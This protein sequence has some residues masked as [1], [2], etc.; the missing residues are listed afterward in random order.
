[1]RRRDAVRHWRRR[2]AAV[3]SSLDRANANL[4]QTIWNDAAVAVGADVKQMGEG[5]LL[6][7]RGSMQTIVWRHLVMIDHQVT[8]R[9]SMNKPLSQRLLSTVGLPVPDGLTFDFHDLTLARAFVE[10]SSLPC[11]V[12]P[13]GQASGT[14][15][16]CGVESR[17]DLERAAVRAARWGRELLVERQAQGGE[18]RVLVLDGEVLGAV[19]RRAT[20]VHG[21]GRSSIGD[22]IH[23]ENERRITSGWA[24]GGRVLSV[25]LDCLLTLRRA[26]YSL[27]SVPA[28]GAVVTVKTSVHENRAEDNETV[29]HISEPLAGDVRRAAAALELRLAG[30]DLMTP[31]PSTTLD[32]SGGVI[33]EVNHPAGLHF[34]YQVADPK[35]ATPV[36]VPI[37][38]SLLG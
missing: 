18:Y 11:V 7:R 4:Y 32:Q 20:Q 38:N 3:R 34:H 37:L 17:D 33:L 2:S 10:G 15:V 24:S 30:V 23:A 29:T 6:L 22:L 27:G 8:Q 35:T 36:A 21:D 31:D 14:G 28:E 12:K 1:M 19:R 16:T 5:F 26:G 25:D 9:L 13:A